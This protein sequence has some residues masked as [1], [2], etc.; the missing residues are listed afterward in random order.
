MSIEYDV[1]GGKARVIEYRAVPG[2]LVTE[3][4]EITERVRKPLSKKLNPLWWFKNDNEPTI[5]GWYLP[6]RPYWWRF[7][8]WYCRNPLMNFGDYVVGFVDRNYVVHGHS[9]ISVTDWA[10]VGLTGWKWCVIWIG[11]FPFPY[12]SYTGERVL[13]HVG[14]QWG[15]HLC[16]KFNIMRKS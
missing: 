10:D 2:Y 7:I 5:P 15:G 16:A 6:D 9:P 14:W 4:V 1:W 3:T 11:Y 8:F 12:V 13:W